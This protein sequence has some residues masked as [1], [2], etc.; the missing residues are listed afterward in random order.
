MDF[1]SHHIQEL[2]ENFKTLHEAAYKYQKDL[3]LSRKKNHIPSAHLLVGDF[4]LRF[5]K[6][7]FREA[8]LSCLNKGP[9]EVT[10]IKENAIAIQHLAYIM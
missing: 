4:V 6:K 9:Y 8:K 7:P 1:K 2:N 5:V 10:G 3:T